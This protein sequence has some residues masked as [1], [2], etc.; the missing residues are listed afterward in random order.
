MTLHHFCM[1]ITES[2]VKLVTCNFKPQESRRH[3]YD[4]HENLVLFLHQSR[5][6]SVAPWRVATAELI[7]A[8]QVEPTR[9]RSTRKL[10]RSMRSFAYETTVR[11]IGSIMRS[12]QHLSRVQSL[13]TRVPR[14]NSRDSATSW[15]DHRENLAPA[16]QRLFGAVLRD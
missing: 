12:Y 14:W 9:G 11:S 1:R 8:S 3:L 13:C 2:L 7:G 5:Q 4:H 10:E 16:A 15:V 6:F